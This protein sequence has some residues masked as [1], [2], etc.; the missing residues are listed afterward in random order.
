MSLKAT[1]VLIRQG[2][3]FAPLQCHRVH[4]PGIYW[5]WKGQDVDSLKVARIP[6]DSFGTQICVKFFLCLKNV[7]KL[8]GGKRPQLLTIRGSIGVSHRFSKIDSCSS[9]SPRAIVEHDHKPNSYQ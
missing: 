5:V 8:V 4:M 2:R 6:M 1:A 9:S 7:R 3:A